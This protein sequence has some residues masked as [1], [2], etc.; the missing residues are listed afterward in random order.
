METFQYENLV[1]HQLLI[2]YINLNLVFC[3]YLPK[4]ASYA[5]ASS[6]ILKSDFYKEMTTDDFNLKGENGEVFC[7]GY[8]YEAF[9]IITNTKLLGDAG[10]TLDDIKDLSPVLLA[11]SVGAQVA[12]LMYRSHTFL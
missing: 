1:Y 8:C 9:G 2:T 3:A 5:L 11:S 7:A 6:F 12:L 4:K 10:Y